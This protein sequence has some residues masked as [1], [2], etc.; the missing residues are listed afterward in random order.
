MLQLNES[1]K[2]FD[3]MKSLKYLS[4]LKKLRITAALL[5]KKS[6]FFNIIRKLTVSDN[7]TVSEKVQDFYSKLIKELFW[8]LD[9]NNFWV[10]F[11]SLK[12]RIVSYFAGFPN[13][14]KEMI[15]IPEEFL[16]LSSEDSISET[17]DSE[18]ENDKTKVQNTVQEEDKN[19]DNIPI[20]K[21]DDDVV[22][23]GKNVTKDRD[24]I[25]RSEID[26][27][28]FLPK[29]R[30]IFYGNKKENRKAMQFLKV[31][32]L[33][34]EQN[35]FAQIVIN[36]KSYLNAKPE[37]IDFV[38]VF[39]SF[40]ELKL[41]NYSA[42]LLLKHSNCVFIIKTLREYNIKTASSSKYLKKQVEKIRFE[43]KKLYIYYKSFF[44]F[45]PK[46]RNFWKELVDSK[47]KLDEQMM[48]MSED[49]RVGVTK[50]PFELLKSSQ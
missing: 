41:V 36:I 22:K 50:L 35:K 33:S 39:H 23:F 1:V 14:F 18:E 21:P 24:A 27:K 4:E 16:M 30:V 15:E 10:S 28:L 45:F 43:S 26:N 48:N 29:E 46:V 34:K 49:E 32:R 6:F 7:Q 47:S 37:N 8:F 17:F 5:I 3:E 31:E 19:F 44:P 12:A 25:E 20:L 40:D 11:M 42:L 9:H 2:C 13:G 38:A